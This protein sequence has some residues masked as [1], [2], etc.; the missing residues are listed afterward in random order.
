MKAIIFDM[1]GTI[2][3]S[4]KEYIRSLEQTL[5]P[6]AITIDTQDYLMRLTGTGYKNI[7]STVLK[8]HHIT[9]EEP[10]RVWIDKWAK[11]FED[12]VRSEGIKPIPGFLEFNKQLNE[13]GIKKII[14]TSSRRES[15]LAVLI[16]LG[17]EKEFQAITVEDITHVKPHPEIFLKAAQALQEPP[18]NCLVFEDSQSGIQAAKAAGCKV[19]A[20]TTTLPREEVEKQHPDLVVKDFTEVDL[21]NLRKL[22]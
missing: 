11:A 6:F 7:L 14:A 13:E 15:V 22:F 18:E 3:D 5:V 9:L 8:E 16:S 10:L 2:I 12:I 1:D 20:L 4:E 21:G 19:A 17:L